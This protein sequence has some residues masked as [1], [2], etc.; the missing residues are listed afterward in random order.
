M[1]NDMCMYVCMYIYIIDTMRVVNY[2]EALENTSRTWPEGQF[3]YKHWG[4]GS[5]QNVA[6]TYWINTTGVFP[7][8]LPGMGSIW[9]NS[10]IFW[11]EME[12]SIMGAPQELEGS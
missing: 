5:S 1:Y 6:L 4:F 7:C 10:G 9:R 11:P 12:V 3:N 8:F 2:D